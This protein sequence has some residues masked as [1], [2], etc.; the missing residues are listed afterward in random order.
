MNIYK[1]LIN[2]DIKKNMGIYN[3]TD[4]FFA[5]VINDISNKHNNILI[6]VDTVYE[7]NKL[8]T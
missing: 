8:F 1:E 4:D 7:A 2:L 3:M 5:F 6:V